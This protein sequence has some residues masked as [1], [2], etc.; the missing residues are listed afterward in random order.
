MGWRRGRQPEQGRP[1]RR[2][3]LAVGVRTRNRGPEAQTLEGNVDSRRAPSCQGDFSGPYLGRTS[4][5]P[6][7]A[8]AGRVFEFQTPVCLARQAGTGVAPARHGDITGQTS[9]VLPSVAL[10]GGPG[11]LRVQAGGS[12]RTNE[13]SLVPTG[14][15]RRKGQTGVPAGNAGHGR[16]KRP[17]CGFPTA[18]SRAPAGRAAHGLT[19][20]LPGRPQCRD[21]CFPLL[22]S[23]WQGPR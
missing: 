5:A 2:P 3:V 14:D 4:L 11:E 17:R 13:Q 21:P 12:T 7:A 15:R 9:G 1:A 23:P 18:R 16:R 6:A 19:S 20:T 10:E 8:H 22:P